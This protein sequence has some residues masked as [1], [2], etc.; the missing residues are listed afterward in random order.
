MKALKGF[1]VT[2]RQM[3]LRW[4]WL[5]TVSKLHRPRISDA[6][7]ADAV[8]TTSLLHICDSVVFCALHD[9]LASQDRHAQLTRCFSA[10]AELFVAFIQNNSFQS[11]LEHSHQ[12]S[13]PFQDCFKHKPISIFLCRKIC[14]C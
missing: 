5:Y 14:R 11:L 12:T 9:Q 7:L 13:G 8:D 2:Q 3:V 6:F 10:V 4:L 1:L